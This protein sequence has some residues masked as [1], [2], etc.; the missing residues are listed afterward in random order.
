M[1]RGLSRRLYLPVVSAPRRSA[2]RVLVEVRVKCISLPAYTTR[3]E[4]TIGIRFA[5]TAF[6]TTVVDVVDIHS[7]LDSLIDRRPACSCVPVA[8]RVPAFLAALRTPCWHRDSHQRHH[9]RRVPISKPSDGLA[10]PS[11]FPSAAR[12]R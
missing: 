9:L 6:R 2:V 11:A 8:L 12:G 4:N 10:W 5:Q 3:I 7:K 1:A